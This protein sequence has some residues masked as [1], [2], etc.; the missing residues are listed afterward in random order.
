MTLATQGWSDEMV[1]ILRETHRD[2]LSFAQISLKVS[3]LGRR[4]SR[5]ACI[6]KAYR[7]GLPQRERATGVAVLGPAR[8]SAGPVRITVIADASL[9]PHLH[10]VG[11]EIPTPNAKP[12]TERQTGECTWIISDD[13]PA[14]DWRSCCAPT[15][16]R[17]LCSEHYEL[18][19]KP[20]KKPTAVVNDQSR[21]LKS[22]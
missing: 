15:H 6:G 7:L 2:G 17:D 9:G 16:A 5:S 12:W 8:R 22:A 21:A 1:E 19:W 10:L 20:R 18:A 3:A 14:A 4:Q 11:S 13:G